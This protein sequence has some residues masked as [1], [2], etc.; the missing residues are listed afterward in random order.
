MN[1]L[2]TLFYALLRMRI[3]L[4]GEGAAVYM[5]R[6]NSHPAAH[7]LRKS[8]VCSSIHRILDII[9]CHNNLVKP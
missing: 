4:C 2:K 8:S 6:M 9:F 5:D 3:V 7:I 1:L